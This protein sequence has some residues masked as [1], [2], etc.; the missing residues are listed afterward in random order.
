ME[1]HPLDHFL[2]L[3]FDF[4][5]Q[6]LE[7]CE[8]PD[9]RAHLSSQILL[10]DEMYIDKLKFAFCF[11]IAKA[12]EYLH[13]FQ[14]PIVHRDLRSPNVTKQKIVF[15]LKF[16]KKRGKKSGQNHK[17]YKIETIFDVNFERFKMIF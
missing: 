9:L 2:L 12:L 1:S 11:D 4:F 5:F 17:K 7:F 8:L 14:P 15:F 13:S 6:V 16:K 3:I 10:P